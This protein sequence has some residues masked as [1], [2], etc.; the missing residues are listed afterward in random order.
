MMYTIVLCILS[1]TSGIFIGL[2]IAMEH[3]IK[4]LE[5]LK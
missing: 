4:F 2:I 1:A 5:K 3:S